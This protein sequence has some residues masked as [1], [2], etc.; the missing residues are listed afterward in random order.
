MKEAL[1]L[2]RNADRWQEFETLLQDQRRRDPDKLASLFVQLTDDL[3]YARTFYPDSQT[4]SYLNALAGKAHQVIYKRKQESHRRFITFWTQEIPMEVYK[5]RSALMLSLIVF[6]LSALI[7]IVSTANDGTFAELILGDFYVDMTLSNIDA[8]DPMAVYK[9]QD[10]AGMF[11]R[12]T[13]NNV[14]V[15]FKA[16]A[17]GVFA[18]VGTLLILV[19]NGVMVGAFQFFFNEHGLLAES[20]AVI[21]IHGTIE[22]SA[23]IIAGGAGFA[24]GNSILFPGT[25]S[26]RRSFLMGA[27]RGLK[28]IV[29]LVPFFVIAGFLES[30]VTRYTQMPLPI[31]LFIIGASLA[32]ML[33]YF[34]VLPWKHSRAADVN[35]ENQ[36]ILVP[37]VKVDGS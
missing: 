13:Q 14:M 2:K 9:K 36:D 29:G 6:V 11:I 12:I 31:S 30:F 3:S 37:R 26:R 23:I 35:T 33:G 5:A 21:W 28:I 19:Q 20:A 22:I 8:G 17:M 27:R 4:V 34:V 32:L 25:Y 24:M 15:A 7:G 16:F 1:F 18:S 10:Q